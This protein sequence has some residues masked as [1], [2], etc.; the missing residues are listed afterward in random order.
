MYIKF[1]WISSRYCA[2]NGIHY[3]QRVEFRLEFIEP[4]SQEMVFGF[5]LSRCIVDIDKHTTAQLRNEMDR[6]SLEHK[7]D[8]MHKHCVTINSI[9]MKRA[10]RLQNKTKLP[11]A[12]HFTETNKNVFGPLK[13]HWN[14]IY[15]AISKDEK[16][17]SILLHNRLKCN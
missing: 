8:D 6:V 14:L 1:N 2:F 15:F 16:N 5:I 4:S 13:T 3:S 12:L 17:A 9:R 11:N 7:W 10:Q